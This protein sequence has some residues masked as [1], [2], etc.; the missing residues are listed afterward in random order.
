MPSTGG[1]IQLAPFWSPL[2][3]HKWNRSSLARPGSASLGG[4]PTLPGHDTERVFRSKCEAKL[5]RDC[6]SQRSQRER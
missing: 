4:I 5:D 2:S 6:S 1:L 3:E